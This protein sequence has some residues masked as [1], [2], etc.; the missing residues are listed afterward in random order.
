MCSILSHQ[1]EVRQ[2]CEPPGREK[3]KRE[4]ASPLAAATA[5]AGIQERQKVAGRNHCQRRD[6]NCSCP[7]SVAV[8][9]GVRGPSQR[10]LPR[11]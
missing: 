4:E 3:A 10:L 5:S 2:G 11:R 1:S 6:V 7:R 8:H 9:G